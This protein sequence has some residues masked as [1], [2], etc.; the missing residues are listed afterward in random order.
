MEDGEPRVS[1]R[2]WVNW[3]RTHRRSRIEDGGWRMEDRRWR[4]AGDVQ[5]G[6]VSLLTI[7]ESVYYDVMGEFLPASHAVAP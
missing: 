2:G 4:R 5:A 7:V 1:A 6:G 3:F